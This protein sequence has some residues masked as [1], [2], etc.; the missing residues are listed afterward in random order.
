MNS[1]LKIVVLTGPRKGQHIVLKPDIDVPLENAPYILEDELLEFR[2]I[3]SDIYTEAS[4]KVYQ[5]IISFSQLSVFEDNYVEFVWRPNGYSYKERLFLN[6]FGISELVV[7][8]I[9]NNEETKRLFFQPIQILAK[10]E[11]IQNV[12]EMFSYLSHVVPE[13]LYAVFS[14]TKSHG[15]IGTE[16][17]G[18]PLEFIERLKY[19]KNLLE[20]VLPSLTNNPIT[21]LE[22]QH[23]FICPTGKEELSDSSISWLM[24]NLSVLEP[25]E[26][27]DQAHIFYDDQHYRASTMYIPVLVENTDVYENQVIH[28]YLDLLIRESCGLLDRYTAGINTTLSSVAPTGYISFFERLNNFRASLIENKVVEI[29]NIINSL[30]SIQSLLDKYL[31][32]TKKITKRPVFTPK[33]KVNYIYRSV[34]LEIVSWLEKKSIDWSSFDNLFSINSLS[35][36][37]ETYCYFR[38]V[39]E[40]NHILLGSQ[41]SL[42][43]CFKFKSEDGAVELLIEREP[44]YWTVNHKNIHSEGIVN[45]E[46]YTVDNYNNFG[47]RGSKGRYSKR[48]PD[49]VLQIKNN[50]VLKLLVLDA[51][52]TRE[53]IAFTRYLPDLT[54]KYVHGIHKYQQAESVV[55]SLA[56]LYPSE[57][58]SF[59]SYHHEDMQIFGLYPVEPSIQA[60]G[61]ILGED[62]YK[63]GLGHFLKRVLVLNG[64]SIKQRWVPMNI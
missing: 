20:E 21:R 25:N 51:K 41:N 46:G 53:K 30:R 1:V 29:D 7:E 3:V 6:Y 39:K 35:L 18:S 61:V 22:P 64:I 14:A 40:I 11:S 45:S 2:I 38:V 59:L 34:F 9:D 5:H 19:A 24:E 57:K 12:N 55:T 50:D 16:M 27:P 4:L 17:E 26:N 33:V 15:A 62:R 49:I 23:Q 13:E 32:V 54:M 28:G 44:N 42:D 60:L 43:L 47:T 52:Y 48:Q 63:D 8:L 37:F 10:T 31:P 36:L 58:T 56:I